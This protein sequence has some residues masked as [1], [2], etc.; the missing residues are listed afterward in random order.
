MGDLT[1]GPACTNTVSFGVAKPVFSTNKEDMRAFIDCVLR[2]GNELAVDVPDSDSTPL[3][4]DARQCLID[5]LL[6][7]VYP[8]D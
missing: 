3:N 2:T 1:L 5:R 6:G 8:D 4:E 7:L